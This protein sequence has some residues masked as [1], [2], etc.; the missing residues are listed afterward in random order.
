MRRRQP[1]SSKILKSSRAR[2]CSHEQDEY[3]RDSEGKR[4]RITRSLTDWHVDSKEN[5]KGAMAEHCALHGKRDESSS[6]VGTSS[7]SFYLLNPVIFRENICFQ[8]S[9]A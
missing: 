5:D 9:D 1:I 3:K 8:S 4:H 6:V 7:C 2:F